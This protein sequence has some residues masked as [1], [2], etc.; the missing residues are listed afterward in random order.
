MNKKIKVEDI[1]K[2][3]DALNRDSAKPDTFYMFED[4]LSALLKFNVLSG[5][6]EMDDSFKKAGCFE[7]RTGSS[8]KKISFNAIKNAEKRRKNDKRIKR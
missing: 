3:I 4:D 8:V 7:T 1:K 5:F 2:C 6:K